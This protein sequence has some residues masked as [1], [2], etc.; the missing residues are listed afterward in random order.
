MLN[1]E[2]C[3]LSQSGPPHPAA[4]PAGGQQWGEGQRSLALRFQ[5]WAGLLLLGH[6]DRGTFNSFM[7]ALPLGKASVSEGGEREEIRCIHLK[8]GQA[9]FLVTSP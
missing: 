8:R 7:P 4:G 1:A 2:H 5:L 6:F 3:A 9:T